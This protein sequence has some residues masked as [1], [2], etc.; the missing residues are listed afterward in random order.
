MRIRTNRTITEMHPNYIS[1]LKA[2]AGL[3]LMLRAYG[4]SSVKAKKIMSNQSARF[5]GRV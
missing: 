4:Y 2:T 1:W 5:V 3:F